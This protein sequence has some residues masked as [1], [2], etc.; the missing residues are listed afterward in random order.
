VRA[1]IGKP[2]ESMYAH[3]S[4]DHVAALSAIYC[5]HY[6]KHFTEHSRPHPGV[7]EL[8]SELKAR[9]YTLV[10]ATKKRSSIARGLVRALGLGDQ[11]D[12]VQGTDGIPYKPA[13][14]VI[15]R[16]LEAVRGEGTW[17]VG[18]TVHDILAGRAAGLKTYAVT[19]GTHRAEALAEAQPDVLA[20][21]LGGLLERL[22]PLP[23]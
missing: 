19:Y 8:L 1:Q 6:P 17:M 23:P 14:D 2:L 11:L 20:E 7:P 10:V 22:P 3:F 16:A 12:F 18:D 9:G 15:Y 13:P 21:D 5:E 4:P